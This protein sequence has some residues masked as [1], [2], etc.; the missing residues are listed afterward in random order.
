MNRYLK[1]MGAFLIANFMSS[2]SFS[3]F[4]Q[5]SKIQLPA[6]NKNGNLAVERFEFSK[7]I[8]D[9]IS[10]S[11]GNELLL[12]LKNKDP[13][14]GRGRKS[15]FMK[16]DCSQ[17]S[18]IW[19]SKAYPCYMTKLF[20]EALMIQHV[21]LP[22]EK[23]LLDL[24]NGKKLWEKN[25]QYI[26]YSRHDS[27]ILGNVIV[28]DYVFNHYEVFKVVNGFSAKNGAALWSKNLPMENW[29]QSSI[30]LNDSILIYE[31]NGIHSINLK[32]KDIWS[33]VQ[34]SEIVNY[35]VVSED[36]KSIIYRP[37]GFIAP[38][39]KSGIQSNFIVYGDTIYHAGK[40]NIVSISRSGKV[41]WETTLNQIESTK[42]RIS[43]VD[44]YLI[45]FN[46]GILYRN[47]F[48]DLDGSPFIRIFERKTG[49]Q[50]LNQEFKSGSIIKD[51]RLNWDAK[52]CYVHASGS[53]VLMINLA[54]KI[55]SAHFISIPETIR[56]EFSSYFDHDFYYVSNN[57]KAVYYT[58]T[59]S[60]IHIKTKKDEIFRLDSAWNIKEK[61]ELKGALKLVY[62][63][64][65]FKIYQNKENLF[66]TDH[67]QNVLYNTNSGWNYEVRKDYL[68]L[69]HEKFIDRIRISDLN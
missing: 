15:S 58:D 48:A 64:P 24:K 20:D 18:I 66:V 31:N 34:P 35:K 27:T 57:Q 65:R 37:K 16:F 54:D 47:S 25:F 44:D 26:G 45:L 50:I 21:V 69:V 41:L 22:G 40:N 10:D 14:T 1:A 7:Y 68:F 36:T 53:D 59:T 42:S 52:K 23:I 2:P 51:F 4:I 61:L 12:S 6:N 13:K 32:T 28:L 60:D 29:T 5:K 19:Q 56:D 49:K 55:P 8:D 62:V 30:K 38:V 33:Y 39:L 67:S 11:S 63:H 43:L 17:T 46:L 9:I 3:Q